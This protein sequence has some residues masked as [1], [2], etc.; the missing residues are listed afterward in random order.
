M[1]WGNGGGRGAT[2]CSARP[3]LPRRP[4]ALAVGISCLLRAG[5][6]GAR[7]GTTNSLC[8][9]AGRRLPAPAVRTAPYW[10]TFLRRAQLGGDPRQGYPTQ[11]W[12]AHPVSPSCEPSS[13]TF[14]VMQL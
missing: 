14:R 4:Q 10:Q 9:G 11:G 1:C 8:P 5:G 2:C 3:P 12:P 7:P 13:G 6:R